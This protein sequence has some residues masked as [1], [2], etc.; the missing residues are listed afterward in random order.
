M[1]LREVAILGVRKY[2][3]NVAATEIAKK[4]CID[5]QSVDFFNMVYALTGRLVAS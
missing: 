4:S 5:I 1:F 2:V 3:C